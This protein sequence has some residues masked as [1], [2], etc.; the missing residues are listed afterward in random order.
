MATREAERREAADLVRQEALIEVKGRRPLRLG[1]VHMR[2]AMEGKRVPGELE[3]HANGIRYRNQLRTD[4]RID[5]LFENIKHFFFQPCDG[6]M[7]VLLHCHLK[8]HIMIGKK[9]TKDVQFFR[10]AVE[11]ASDETAAGRR[12]KL[13]AYGDDD[14]L[15]QEQEE[16]RR[17]AKLNDEFKAF[18]ARIAEQS[19]HAVDVDMPLRDLGFEGVPVRQNVL[20]M[21]T[22]ECLVQLIDPPFTVVTMA[23]VEIAHLERVVFGLKSFDLVF[24][25][26]DH[27]MAP[28]TVTSIPMAFLEQVKEWLDS[29]D[30][31][32]A[33]ST[34]N[35]NWSNIMKT[36][37]DDAAGFY[38]TGGWSFLQTAGAEAASDSASDDD[39]GDSAYSASDDGDEEDASDDDASDEE[40]VSEDEDASEEAYSDASDDDEEDASA[41]EDAPDWDELEAEAERHDRKAA[42]MHIGG[43]S[44]SEHNSRVAPAKRRK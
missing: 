19:T 36:I 40:V 23:D 14:E 42:S 26:K 3:I 17:R 18:A 7:V 29:M 39:E 31:V 8:N 33:E 30:V 1:D 25:F 11:A 12:R 37:N 44:S 35:L 16:R 22:R 9:R 21:P 2:P 43:G 32:F 4:Q 24:V 5:I 34:I 15:L 28:Y 13:P 20:L 38:E 41:D 6:E 10:E 27:K